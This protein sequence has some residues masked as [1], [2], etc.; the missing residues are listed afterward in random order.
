[1]TT[2][3][4]QGTYT[5]VAVELLQEGNEKKNKKERKT[6]GKWD[7]EYSIGKHIDNALLRYT[8]KDR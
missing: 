6:R 4:D 3:L 2:K 5:Y 8:E 1:M 7:G